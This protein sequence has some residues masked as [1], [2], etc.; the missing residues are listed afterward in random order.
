MRKQI[1]HF[2]SSFSF[3]VAFGLAAWT[4]QPSNAQPT[5]QT[6]ASTRAALLAM[7]QSD[8]RPTVKEV[9]EAVA[10]NEDVLY[11]LAFEHLGYGRGQRE[12]ST[13]PNS[14]YRTLLD[15]NLPKA[16]T[17]L[18]VYFPNG[19]Y[20]TL[21]RDSFFI[22]DTLEAFYLGLG[23]E[24][25]V[26]RLGA[27][28]QTFHAFGGDPE[29]IY[30]FVKSNG[31]DMKAAA[32]GRMPFV[33]IDRTSYSSGSQ[34]TTL[35][36][37]VYQSGEFAALTPQEKVNVHHY[38][39]VASSQNGTL[40]PI[41]ARAL[42]NFRSTQSP[43]ARLPGLFAAHEFAHFTDQSHLNW[44][45]TFQTTITTLPDGRISGVPGRGEEGS[46]WETL[47][48]MYELYQ[49]L[50]TPEFQTLVWNTARAD[51]FDIEKTIDRTGAGRTI[52]I[53]SN[54]RLDQLIRAD[55]R[56]QFYP[57]AWEMLTD[58]EKD[59]SVKGH[60][61]SLIDLLIDSRKEFWTRWA[62]GAGA[63]SPSEKAAQFNNWRKT[64]LAE[65]RGKWQPETAFGTF[66]NE[67]AFDLPVLN[68][69]NHDPEEYH[70]VEGQEKESYFSRT[71]SPIADA[72]KVWRKKLEMGLEECLDLLSWVEF[73]GGES[74]MTSKD[75][76]RFVLIALS[77]F[78]EISVK[79]MEQLT[80]KV[81]ES[82]YVKKLLVDHPKVFLTS[83]RYNEGHARNVYLALLESGALP[84]TKACKAVLEAQEGEGN[85]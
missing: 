2:V 63:L 25:R 57:S 23:L 48:V 64:D 46:R 15:S 44:H 7:V 29:E 3:V 16:I 52:G 38:A 72:I 39:V 20:A 27:S 56:A 83:T 59:L 11:K 84:K 78:N 71:V 60:P 22:A 62:I 70:K 40:L 43:T 81:N 19:K 73:H 32:E 67:M 35:L 5:T 1:F 76:R 31:F 26:V 49:Y 10:G 24:N 13:S 42:E 34:S 66:I 79:S 30:K 55:I 69:V 41:T 80:E 9:L 85:D 37:S 65:L 58:G 14:G 17:R 53:R 33:I 47:L 61:G 51:G 8:F 28:T 68:L 54:S 50:K 6:A 36:N 21:G 4:P 45:P 12:P 77:F 75:A 82:R 74:I 18:E